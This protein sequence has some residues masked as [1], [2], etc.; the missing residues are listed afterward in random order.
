MAGGAVMARAVRG[1][2]FG[3]RPLDPVTF[4]AVPAL[5]AAVAILASWLPARRAA[6]VQASEALRSE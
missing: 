6:A 2:L 1:F 4:V 3:I 5:I